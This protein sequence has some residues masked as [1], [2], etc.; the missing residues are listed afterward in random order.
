MA[1]YTPADVVAEMIISDLALMAD[2]TGSAAWPL[3]VAHEPDIPDNCGTI[4][5]TPGIIESRL[6]SNNVVVVHH[7]FQLRFRGSGY[8]ATWTKLNTVCTGLAGVF[9]QEVTLGGADYTVQACTRTS[10]IVSLG[11]EM[12]NTKRRN[13]FTVN[14]IVTLSVD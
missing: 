3:R 8:S 2:P 1:D 11:K 12:G 10:S 7:G 4:Y 14:Y 5:D 6:M 13:L 9:N